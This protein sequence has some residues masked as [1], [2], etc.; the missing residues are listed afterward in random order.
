MG[1]QAWQTLVH[2]CRRWR[3]V[4]LASPRRLNLQLY[5]KLETPAKDRLDVWPALP[6]IVSAHMTSSE[7]RMDNVI[8]ALGRS[9]RVCEVDLHLMRWQLEA[10][11]GRDAG[12]IPRVDRSAA[13]VS[14]K[15]YKTAS[16]SRFVLGCICPTSAKLHLA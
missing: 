15:A 7:S 12:A 14:G 6:L 5:C 11:L 8:A 9:N 2:V 1:I 3:S 16:L 4:V 10:A 13:L